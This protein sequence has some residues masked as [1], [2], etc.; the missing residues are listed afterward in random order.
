MPQI[1]AVSGDGKIYYWGGNLFETYNE[2]FDPNAVL[3]YYDIKLGDYAGTDQII[4]KVFTNFGYK[5]IYESKEYAP[6]GPPVEENLSLPG[7]IRYVREGEKIKILEVDG[8]VAKIEAEDGLIGWL[9][10]FHM[11]WD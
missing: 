2:D 8:N 10:S 1:M 7:A 9:G 6:W 4:G 5:V 3:S 11:V